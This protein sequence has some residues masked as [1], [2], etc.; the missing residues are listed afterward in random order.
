[1]SRS[2]DSGASATIQQQFQQQ[3]DQQE[4]I[5]TLKDEIERLNDSNKKLTSQNDALSAKNATLEKELNAI[6]DSTAMILEAGTRS[7]K[8]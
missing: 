7:R 6:K 2:I 3:V 4:I 8:S 1:M 5:A